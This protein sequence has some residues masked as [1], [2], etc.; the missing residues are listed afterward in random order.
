MNAKHSPG[1]WVFTEHREI[2]DGEGKTVAR[3]CGN[4]GQEMTMANVALIKAAPQ[5]LE[6]LY[7]CICVMQAELEGLQ[8]IQ[9]ELKGAREAMTAAM[10]EPSRVVW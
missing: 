7:G 2:V 10:G 8:V 1:P 9:P 3:I 5:L 4:G 6:A